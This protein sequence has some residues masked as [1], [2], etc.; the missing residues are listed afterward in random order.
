MRLPDF[1]YGPGLDVPELRSAFREWSALPLLTGTRHGVRQAFEP[2]LDEAELAQL[3]RAWFD[4]VL[5]EPLAWL[6]HR[7]RVS[8]ALF[9][10]HAP[11]WP[12]GLLYEDA[13]ATYGD[14]PSIEPNRG[15][16]HATLMHL[17]GTL[18]ATPSL[19]AW[20]YLALG[21]AAGVLAWRRRDVAGRVASL[22]LASAWMY[23]LPLCALTASAE[24]RYLG[25]PCVAS[26]LAFACVVCAPR[27]PSAARLD[28]EALTRKDADE[29][30]ATL[31]VQH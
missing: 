12:R 6:R 17:A 16:L 31:H 26:L 18:A 19:A 3:K 8:R 2:P 21:L 23:S 5:E 22:L 9:G 30:R 28:P 1:M 11:D 14:N 7:A 4:A 25:W 27:P 29:H 24:L 13:E 15:A 20:P 10:T